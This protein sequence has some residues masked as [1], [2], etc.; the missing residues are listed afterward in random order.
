MKKLFFFLASLLV[1][2]SM[3]AVTELKPVAADLPNSGDGG[4]S[5][6][7]FH[8]TY[9]GITLDWEGAYYATDFRVY[10]KKS[11]TLSAEQNITK[12][13]FDGRVNKGFKA[14]VSAGE[15]TLGE[16]YSSQTTLSPVLVIEKINAKSITVSVDQQIR[17]SA[18]R[19]FLEGGEEPVEP[20]PEAYF[21]KHPWGTGADEAWAW[22]AL[23]EKDGLWVIED[24]WGGVGANIN[25][26]ASDEGAAW[27]PAAD[28]AGA[29]QIAVGD[30]AKFSYDAEN[31]ALAVEKLGDAPV[32]PQPQDHVYSVAGYAS[33][34]G[35]NWDEKNEATEMALVDGLYTL[36]LDK[37]TLGA[38]QYE[39]KVVVDHN[40]SEAYPSENYVLNIAEPGVYTITIT[41]NAE[42]KEVAANAVK[43][44]DAPQPE[45]VYVVAGMAAIVNGAAWD[46]SNEE[47]KMELVDGVYTLVVKG[48][49]LTAGTYEFKIVKDGSAWIPDGMGNNSQLVIEEAGTYDI[50]FTYKEGD[51]AG[52]ATAVKVGEGPVE[53][54]A[55]YFIKH[56][57]G[58]GLGADW[59][60]KPLTK[61][62]KGLFVIEDAWGGVGANINTVASD[63]GAAWIPAADIAGAADIQVGAK[64]RF[65]YDADAKTLAVDLLQEPVQPEAEYA[66]LINGE[67]QVVL[68]LNAGQTEWTEYF[69]EGV[70]LAE[71][72]VVTFYDVK[73]DVEWAVA[74]VDGTEN[75]ENT[76]NGILVKVA[77]KY[78]FYLKLIEGQD[79]VW[80][81]AD[82]DKPQPEQPIT[83]TLTVPEDWTTVYLWA[84]NENGDIFAAWPG[85]ELPIVDGKA[86]YTFADEV[87]SVQVIFSNGT[88]QTV[89]GEAI[90]ESTCY[91]L[92][93]ADALGHLALVVVDCDTETGLEEVVTGLD[94]NAPMYNVLGMR[95]D[96]YYQGIVIQNG[97][98][99]IRR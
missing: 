73:N 36:V 38:G 65:I 12:V 40:W 47:N 56:P 77:G 53:P 99:F 6:T 95:V 29:D 23:E 58:T 17:A 94:L 66:I 5:D 15:I 19:V 74:I 98:K 24:A 25:T 93:E 35:V 75:I 89:D 31:K 87:T 13:E 32:E 69:V 8:F 34:V 30:K 27:I 28:I 57:W 43:E 59:T 63:E 67:T 71:G 90:T 84:W 60:W 54:E 41:F 79:E 51:E 61:N 82:G 81:A 42:T 46:G 26:V 70:E 72:D 50:T 1:S 83:V 9:S 44:G 3:F 39:F 16:E 97:K 4:A 85:Q 52:A 80:V 2:A 48:K 78:S 62:D 22:K 20:Q 86:S 18:I 49:E 64:V 92:G 96:K 21:I 14:T 11:I 10:A 88:V 7:P 33:L 45:A 68:T 55:E 91:E 76:E 37:L